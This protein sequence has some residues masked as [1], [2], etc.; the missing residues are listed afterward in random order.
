MTLRFLR[1]NA[2]NI[3]VPVIFGVVLVAFWEFFVN[4][5]D[6][7]PYILPTPSSIWKEAV[8]RIHLL[9][10]FPGRTRS[11]GSSSASSSEPRPQ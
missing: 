7:K 3:I 9:R 4:W 10:P 8:K 2:A 6:V 5:R 11:S 1:R